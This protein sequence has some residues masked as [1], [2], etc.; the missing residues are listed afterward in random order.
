MRKSKLNYKVYNGKSIKLLFQNSRILILS[1]L[2]SVGIMLGAV[3][4]NK[5]ADIAER[6]TEYINSYITRKSGQGITDIF[7][8]SIISNGLFFVLNFF[9]AFS[10][11]GYPLIIWIPFLKGLAFGA[12]CGRLYL[13]YGL[14][15]LGYSIL[16]LFPGAT[17]ST[18]SLIIACNISCEYSSNAYSKAILGKGQFEKGETKYF[19]FK[20]TIFMLLIIISSLIDSVF[21]IAFLRFLEF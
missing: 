16:T 3:V 19:I 12:V 10:L 8:N 17:V 18:F 6:I 4:L 20:Q 15:G 11:V 7:F 13:L 2:F 21:S 9:L 1:I 14:S 5:E